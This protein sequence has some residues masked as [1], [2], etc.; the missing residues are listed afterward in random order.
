M[1]WF[2]LCLILCCLTRMISDSDNKI[3]SS[4]R[5][6]PAMNKITGSLLEWTIEVFVSYYFN[7]LAVLAI[8]TCWLSIYI[9]IYHYHK[10]WTNVRWNKKGTI[11]ETIGKLKWSS[12]TFTNRFVIFSFFLDM[13]RRLKLGH[14]YDYSIH[15]IKISNFEICLLN[16]D[17][18]KLQ[19]VKTKTI[20]SINTCTRLGL[21]V[22]IEVN[23]FSY[24]L[25]A[26]LK[27]RSLLVL[28]I[29]QLYVYKWSM[30]EFF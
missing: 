30:N 28:T 27:M 20:L 4:C 17:F 14:T 12:V 13:P 7:L 8:S 22:F 16:D 1:I 26:L 6:E 9:P 23:K 3:L 25:F 19:E 24:H 15:C 18:A 21:Y 11:I 10:N 2:L 29:F 5:I